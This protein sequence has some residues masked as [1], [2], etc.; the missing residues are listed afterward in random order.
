[1]RTDLSLVRVGAHGLGLPA[2]EVAGRIGV[3]ELKAQLAVPPGDEERR[4][5]RTQ[6]AKLSVRVLEVAELRDDVLHRG[7]L[8]VGA[9]IALRLGARGVNKRVRVRG[10]ARDGARHV[11]VDGVETLGG[12]TDVEE[13]GADALAG[14]EDDAVGRHDAEG[15]TG[16]GDGLDR[17]FDLVETTCGGGRQ[18]R[19]VDMRGGKVRANKVGMEKVLRCSPNMKGYF[20]KK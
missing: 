10:D 11:G 16:L 12:R 6:A 9:Q 19:E 5:E 15:G 14:G 7:L 8:L 2:R 17:I 20:K 1:L 18:R 4:A 3:V 13:G